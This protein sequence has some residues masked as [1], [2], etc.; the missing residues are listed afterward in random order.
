MGTNRPNPESAAELLARWRASG[1]DVNAA[2]A[3]AVIAAHALEW[4]N[5]AQEAASETEK[6]AAAASEA[7]QRALA[8]AQSA[9][10]A[11]SFAAEAAQLILATAEGD[12]VRANHDVELATERETEA[13]H[14]FHDAEARGFPKGSE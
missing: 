2:Q 6:A 14:R 8:A 4:A 13:A 1:R 11:A 5:A 10:R 9:K 7:V 3:A 12:K